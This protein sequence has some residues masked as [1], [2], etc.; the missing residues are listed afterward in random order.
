MARALFPGSLRGRASG[1]L[2]RLNIWFEHGGVRF[3]FVDWGRRAKASSTPG[4]FEFLSRALEAGRPAVILTH[5]HVTPIGVAWLDAFIADD[6]DRFWEIV[7]HKH[8]LGV[9]SGHVHMTTET[10]VEGIPVLTLRSTAFQFAR[11]ARPL[12]T[13]EPPHYRLVT[14]DGD[15]LTSRVFEVAL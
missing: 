7:R 5:H 10:V 4:M 3:V 15:V 12:L 9:L 8:V 11:Q 1:S 13:L 6:V 14:I 2:D